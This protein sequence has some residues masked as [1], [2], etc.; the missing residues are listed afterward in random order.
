MRCLDS[1]DM[2]G[3]KLHLRSDTRS[4]NFAGASPLQDDSSAHGGSIEQPLQL[5]L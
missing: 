4:K 3:V 2:P 1:Q 5:L